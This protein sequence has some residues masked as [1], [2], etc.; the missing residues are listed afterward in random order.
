[1]SDPRTPIGVADILVLSVACVLHKLRRQLV[2]YDVDRAAVCSALL[3]CDVFAAQDCASLAC[4]A[5]CGAVLCCV[6]L[7][8]AVLRCALTR[9]AMPCYAILCDGTVFTPTLAL[10]KH[11][12]DTQ[13]RVPAPFDTL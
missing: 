11:H 2:L 9:Y 7:C 1:M 6:V 4:G 13:G 3:C 8:C 10:H 12:P 5:L